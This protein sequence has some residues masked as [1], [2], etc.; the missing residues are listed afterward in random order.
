MDVST[1]DSVPSPPSSAGTAVPGDRLEA[2]RKEE[3]ERDSAGK[4]K[5]TTKADTIPSQKRHLASSRVAIPASVGLESTSRSSSSA[6]ARPSIAHCRH[7]DAE[8]CESQH[9]YVAF[10][11][12]RGIGI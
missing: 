12:W 8:I 11:I 3:E 6:T 1:R 10:R 9:N 7:S 2:A 5:T 4:T